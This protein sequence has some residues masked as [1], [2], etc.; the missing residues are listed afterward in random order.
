MC[1]VDGLGG[2]AQL[3]FAGTTLAA[4][5]GSGYAYASNQGTSGSITETETAAVLSTGATAEGR[6][7]VGLVDQWQTFSLGFE[8]EYARRP[9]RSEIDYLE[10]RVLASV[11]VASSGAQRFQVLFGAEVGADSGTPVYLSL[12]DDLNSGNW[13]LIQAD[14]TS[15][16]N[17]ALPRTAMDDD[18][19]FVLRMTPLTAEGQ[20]TRFQWWQQNWNTGELDLIGDATANFPGFAATAGQRIRWDW[21]AEIIKSIGTTARTMDV[22]A[23]QSRAVLK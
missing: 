5:S 22:S 1:Y 19:W 17:S 12:R 2:M 21:S 6:A 23:L 13:Q 18:G 4:I 11:P 8:T 15:I 3:D 9:A 20:S 10:F 7:A 16:I 14:G